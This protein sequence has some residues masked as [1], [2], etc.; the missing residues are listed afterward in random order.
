MARF[1]LLA[2]IPKIRSESLTE[3]TSGLVITIA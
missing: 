3:E 1:V 2:N